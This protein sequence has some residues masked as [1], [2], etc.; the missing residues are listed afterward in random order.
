MIR[1]SIKLL[2]SLGVYGIDRVRNGWARQ[3]HP[4]TGGRGVVLYY[5]AVRQAQRGAFARQMDILLRVAHPWNLD[6]CLD[7]ANEPLFAVTFDDGYASVIE[8]ALPELQQRGIPATVFVPTG[9][10]GERP[11]WIKSLD[12]PLRQERVM[13]REELKRL[14]ADPLVTIGSHTVSHPNLLAVS[15]REASRELA[16]SKAELENLLGRHV[17]WLSFPHGA[18]DASLV[19]LALGTGYRRVFTINPTLVDPLQPGVVNGRVAVDPDDWPLE[20]FLKIHG[21]YRWQA[22]LKNTWERPTAQRAF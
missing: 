19:R 22:R 21:A 12:H 14:A 1:R 2:L 4:S 5:H 10:W 15:A 9:S 11:H 7:Q 8:N 3:V 6:A 17:A 13:S 16:A 20:F 18:Y